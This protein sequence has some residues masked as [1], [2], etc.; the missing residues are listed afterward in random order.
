MFSINDYK[1]GVDGAK[2]TALPK[3]SK[4]TV[5]DRERQVPTPPANANVYGITHS[6]PKGRAQPNALAC[7]AEAEIPRCTRVCST[8]GYCAFCEQDCTLPGTVYDY[9]FFI[10][11]VSAWRMY[12]PSTVRRR[13]RSMS[14]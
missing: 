2:S 9:K 12:L 3:Q 14:S 11:T 1:K 13:R 4:H 6:G 8:R 5:H 7:A 10:C